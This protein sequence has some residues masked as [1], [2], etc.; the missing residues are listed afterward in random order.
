MVTE[1][2]LKYKK[3]FVAFSQNEEPEINSYLLF[4]QTI[5]QTGKYS[6]TEVPFC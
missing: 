3:G 2:L 6:V 1:C 5:K 4:K